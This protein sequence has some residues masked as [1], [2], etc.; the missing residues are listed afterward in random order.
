MILSFQY[1][2]LFKNTDFQLPFFCS[3]FY[4]LGLTCNRRGIKVS[5]SRI[6][7]D[8]SIKMLSYW[9]N[10]NRDA[11][12]PSNTSQ[13]CYSTYQKQAS[14]AYL[15]NKSFFISRTITATS[16]F[17]GKISVLL[18]QC[19]WVKFYYINGKS[20]CTYQALHLEKKKKSMTELQDMLPICHNPSLME[21]HSTV[22]QTNLEF[23]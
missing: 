3:M 22:E 6:C 15:G 5:I 14:I 11:Y 21:K 23:L 19:Q 10:K 7:A 8:S 20:I 12:Q 1:L 13:C 18:S 16:S 17:I 9:E 2:V 4:N